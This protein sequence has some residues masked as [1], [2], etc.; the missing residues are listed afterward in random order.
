MIAVIDDVLPEDKRVAV[1]NY[2]SSSIEARKKQWYGGTYPEFLAGNSPLC[3]LVIK[4]SKFIDTNNM[5]GCEYWGH[6]QSK[7]DWHID[8]DEALKYKTNKINLP[9]CG[10]VYYPIAENLI[11][12]KF[13]TETETVTPVTNRM[14]IMS[15]GIWHRVEDYSGLRMSVAVNIWD[16]ILEEFK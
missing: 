9:L 16:Y 10:I 11:G 6:Y 1:K 8:T 4:A 14:L 3:D 7:P 2:F 12:G 15:P 5:V 13:M